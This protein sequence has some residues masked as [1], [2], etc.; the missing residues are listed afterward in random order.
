MTTLNPGDSVLLTIIHKKLG[1]G[2]YRREKTVDL[3]E[4]GRSRRTVLRLRHHGFENRESSWPIIQKTG[5]VRGWPACCRNRTPNG[6]STAKP[7]MN[8][9]NFDLGTFLP[10][11]RLERQRGSDRPS[12]PWKRTL[13]TLEPGAG[14]GRR[15]FAHS[16]VRG[17]PYAVHNHLGIFEGCQYV[18]NLLATSNNILGIEMVYR[19]NRTLFEPDGETAADAFP[20]VQYFYRIGAFSRIKDSLRLKAVTG[21]RAYKELA[22]IVGADPDSVTAYGKRVPLSDEQYSVALGTFELSLY[23]QLHLYNVL[24][25]N[26]LIERPADHPSLVIRSIVLNGDTM[27]STDTVKRFHPFADIQQPAADPARH[28]QEAGLQCR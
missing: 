12:V 5:S 6:S 22:R 17:K 7:I 10:Y 28:A 16:A 27:A 26:D 11:A 20:L 3:P 9:L 18:F 14:R 23:E 8:A 2:L 21:V 4:T 13:R 19:L 15:V 1:P 24:Y 25:N